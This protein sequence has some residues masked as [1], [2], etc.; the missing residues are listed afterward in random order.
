MTKIY[1]MFPSRKAHKGFY[2][3]PAEKHSLSPQSCGNLR[4]RADLQ[5]REESHK[6]KVHS[7]L[8]RRGMC[9]CGTVSALDLVLI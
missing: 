6:K 8:H 9:P 3:K 4:A 2:P 5:T 1:S 7:V